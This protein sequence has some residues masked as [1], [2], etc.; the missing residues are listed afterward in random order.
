MF[1]QTVAA[2]VRAHLA[3]RQ[4]SSR[5]L[6]EEINLTPSQLSRRLNGSIAFTVEE[7]GE[8]AK[9][10]NVTVSALYGETSGSREQAVAR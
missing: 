10:L 4:I 3:R 8:I 6:A 2:E 9:V 7:V 5:K 1:T